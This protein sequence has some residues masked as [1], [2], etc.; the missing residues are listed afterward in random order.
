MLIPTALAITHPM[1][2]SGLCVTF[3]VLTLLCVSPKLPCLHQDYQVPVNI[4]IHNCIHVCIY[5]TFR[6]H[7]S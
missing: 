5:L 4:I 1:A 6:L 3:Y 2:S 7:A